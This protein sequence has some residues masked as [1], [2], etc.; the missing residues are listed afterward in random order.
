MPGHSPLR[1]RLPS[2]SIY[3]A[4]K[5]VWPGLT[6]AFNPPRAP[7]RPRARPRARPRFSAPRP[8]VGVPG[9]QTGLPLSWWAD[10]LVRRD[11]AGRGRTRPPAASHRVL[12]HAPPRPEPRASTTI[13]QRTNRP[14][15]PPEGA[16][17]TGPWHGPNYLSS[18]YLFWKAAT[19]IFIFFP[20]AGAG[21]RRLKRAL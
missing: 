18:I 12:A 21:A 17:A 13:C 8:P 15:A 16:P 2:G 7:V 11:R 9:Y 6:P 3:P 1:A 14:N 19:T 10:P 4:T 20:P 5:L